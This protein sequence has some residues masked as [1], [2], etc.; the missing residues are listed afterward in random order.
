MPQFTY[1]GHKY[2]GPGNPLKSGEPVN[3][4]DA[5]AERHDWEYEVAS[6]REHIYSSDKRAASKF[7]NTYLLKGG[8]N[9]LA[10]WAGLTSKHIVESAL[11]TVIYPRNLNQR[12]Q[13]IGLTDEEFEAYRSASAYTNPGLKRTRLDE[14]PYYDYTAVEDMSG[15]R[16]DMSGQGGGKGPKLTPDTGGVDVEMT[17]QEGDTTIGSGSVRP[18][19][20]APT[21]KPISNWQKGGQTFTHKRIMSTFIHNFKYFDASSPYKVESSA[22]AGKQYFLVTPYAYVPADI[23]GFYFTTNEIAE[24]PLTSECTHFKTIIRPVGFRL[25]FQTQASGTTFANSMTDIIGMYAFGL[26]NTYNG[27][28]MFPTYTSTDPCEIEKVDAHYAL[29]QSYFP[30][31]WTAAEVLAPT[32]RLISSS[33]GNIIPFKDYFVATGVMEEGTAGEPLLMDSI[34]TFDMMNKGNV[35]ITYE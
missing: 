27:R 28:N 16:T 2:L 10:G 33:A 14:T 25:P 30:K 19:T 17:A 32:T 7:F 6:K 1:P 31:P 23:I 9:N 18:A 35:V 12:Q 22:L 20:T 5:T 11:G 8:L 4:A 13:D 15:S 3:E 29:D 21:V 24:L 34:T 26:N